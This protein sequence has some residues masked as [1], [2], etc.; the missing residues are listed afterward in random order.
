MSPSLRAN[1][2]KSYTVIAES[3]WVV[4]TFVVASV[5]VF[6]LADAT[7][8]ND[9]LE[10]T[11]GQLYATVAIYVGGAVAAI[12]PIVAIRGRGY[13]F[14]VLGIDKKPLLKLWWLPFALWPLYMLATSVVAV[15]SQYLLPW[16]DQNQMQEVG[17]QDINQPWEYVMAFFGLVILPPLAEELMFRGYLLGR[18]REKLKPWT[19]AIFVSIVFGL[20]HGQ[21]NVGI[22]V[23]VLSLFL[24]YLRERTGS[25]W[26]GVVLHALKNGIAYFFLF[27]GPLIGINLL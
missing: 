16:V 27:I 12:A 4:L 2:S 9:W 19:A 18:L 23:F 25:I 11:M 17:F 14:Q 22:D 8:L 21:W 20:I 7:G 13:V 15:L 6:A 26:A 5:V 1:A 10:T 24:C 3:A